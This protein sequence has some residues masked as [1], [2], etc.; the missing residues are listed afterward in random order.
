MPAL[1]IFFIMEWY[2]DTKRTTKLLYLS[3]FVLCIALMTITYL[4]L[5]TPGDCSPNSIDDVV[6]LY[7]FL[8]VGLF[9]K[10]W[11]IFLL[12]LLLSFIAIFEKIKVLYDGTA[13]LRS[14][15]GYL[16]EIAICILVM[17][18]VIFAAGL[19]HQ[20]INCGSI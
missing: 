3:Y 10:Y 8:P 12:A 11:I 6:R 1:R 17:S 5:S 13:K 7:V 2:I 18:S 14:G 9:M 15:V 20:F 16:M 19:I 4:L